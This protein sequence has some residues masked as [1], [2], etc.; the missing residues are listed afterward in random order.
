[1]LIVAKKKLIQN[2]DG[3]ISTLASSNHHHHHMVTYEDGD[4]DWMLIG[5]LP[6][7]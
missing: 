2:A 7:E 1:M 5:D 4:G 3:D 6:W